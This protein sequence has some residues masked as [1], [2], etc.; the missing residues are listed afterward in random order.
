MGLVYDPS[1]LQEHAERLYKR[2]TRV[3]IIWTFL[4]V[5]VGFMLGGILYLLPETKNML[6]F[7]S[8]LILGFV[9]GINIGVER[10][11]YLKLEAQRTL[12]QYQIEFNTRGIAMKNM[13]IS[14]EKI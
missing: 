7:Y 12:C 4:G 2:S 6:I 5:L 9:A 10:A 11:F 13:K 14:P 3:G 8:M 1:V